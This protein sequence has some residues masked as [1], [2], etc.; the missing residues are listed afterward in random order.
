M[1]NKQGILDTAQLS[2]N[3]MLRAIHYLDEVRALASHEDK[4]GKPRRAGDSTGMAHRFVVRTEKADGSE[5]EA[6]DWTIVS[7][8]WADAWYKLGMELH[9]FME[10][11]NGRRVLSVEMVKQ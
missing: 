9:D 10:G 2:R 8:N 3:A 1:T 5:R 11:P 7:T 6:S 4:A